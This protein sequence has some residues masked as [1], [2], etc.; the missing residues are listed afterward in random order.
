VGLERGHSSEVI[1]ELR[2]LGHEVDI[3]EHASF[4]G[5]QLIQRLEDGYC[6]ASDHR[7]DGQAVGY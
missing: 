2:A 6:A 5:A 4:G 1:D 7:K 3:L